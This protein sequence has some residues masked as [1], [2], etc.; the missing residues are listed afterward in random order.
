MRS[1][2]DVDVS[3]EGD[4]QRPKGE[5]RV[6]KKRMKFRD[7]VGMSLNSEWL[8]RSDGAQA[9]PLREGAGAG[10]TGRGT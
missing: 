1:E 5:V 3:G 8:R 10:W 9:R 7:G 4:D 6:W 2:E